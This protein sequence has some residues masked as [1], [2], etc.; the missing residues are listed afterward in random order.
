MVIVY[1][2]VFYK[3]DMV[4][5]FILVDKTLSEFGS[6]S[7]YFDISNDCNNRNRYAVGHTYCIL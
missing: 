5:V 7:D 3:P 1:W 6:E 4:S 2:C